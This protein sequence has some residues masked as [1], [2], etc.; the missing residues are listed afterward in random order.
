MAAIVYVCE[1]CH[2]SDRITTKCRI[3]LK[4]HSGKT[5]TPC[6]IC[7][8]LAITAPC[9]AYRRL[10]KQIASQTVKNNT[11]IDDCSKKTQLERGTYDIW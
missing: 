9:F 4:Y 7:G 11:R 5:K 3:A 1:S 6:D 10:A 2:D 8:K